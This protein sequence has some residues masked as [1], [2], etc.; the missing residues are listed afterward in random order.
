MSDDVTLFG[1]P[2][3]PAPTTPPPNT[4]DRLPD[5]QV[6][7]LREALDALELVTM[8]ARKAVVE[9][10]AGRPVRSL[11]DLTFAEARVVSEALAARR[12]S[13]NGSGS[14]WDN[15][16]GDTWIDRL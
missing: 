15:R 14:A 6:T 8:D 3:P 1:D 12:N 4:V 7:S 11:R 10:I 16:D 13:T 9:E 5:W 2:T